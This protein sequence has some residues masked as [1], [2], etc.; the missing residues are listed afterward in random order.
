MAGRSKKGAGLEACV[1]DVAE[2]LDAH[3]EELT[4]KEQ[5]RRLR[6]FERVVERVTH[7]G[8]KIGR[9]HV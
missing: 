4:A 1:S 5:E 7:R 6:A 2:I 9:A 3:L 8:D